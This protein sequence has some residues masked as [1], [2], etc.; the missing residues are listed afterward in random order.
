MHSIHLSLSLPFT[1]TYSIHLLVSPSAPLPPFWD[2][3]C[4]TNHANSWSHRLVIQFLW[5]QDL[6]NDVTTSVLAHSTD[7]PPQTGTVSM[8]PWLHKALYKGMP[9]TDRFKMCR[10]S[11]LKA[12]HLPCFWVSNILQ[13]RNIK[14][15]IQLQGPAPNLGVLNLNCFLSWLLAKKKNSS[16]FSRS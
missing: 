10:L 4:I 3:P 12:L 7:C 1:L 5:E 13:L 14:S 11:L 9:K 2:L 8:Q 6:T 16:Y 15:Q